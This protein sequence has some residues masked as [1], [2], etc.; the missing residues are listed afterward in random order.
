MF[1]LG[2]ASPGLDSSPK[3]H[4]NIAVEGTKGLRNSRNFLSATIILTLVAVS[5]LLAS[6]PSS[7]ER[8][9]V[10]FDDVYPHYCTYITTAE[11]T[12]LLSDGAA[13]KCTL[14]NQTLVTDT[15]TDTRHIQGKTGTS[16]IFPESPETQPTGMR[17]R[18]IVRDA[19]GVVIADEGTNCDAVEDPC[20]SAGVETLAP[21]ESYACGENRCLWYWTRGEHYISFPYPIAWAQWQSTSSNGGCPGDEPQIGQLYLDCWTSSQVTQ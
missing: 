13:F 7:A 14:T 17:I 4:K 10:P 19:T 3:N 12:G 2:Q 20:T 18:A 9:C 6:T 15:T 8:I 1:Q 16:C 5:S 21:P 11:V